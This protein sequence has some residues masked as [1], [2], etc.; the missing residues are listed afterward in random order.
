MERDVCRPTA[1]SL[2]LVPLKMTFFT[3][4]H[5]CTK[6]SGRMAEYTEKSRFGE[7]THFLTG[8][9]Q[10][11]SSACSSQWGEADRQVQTFLGGTDIEDEGR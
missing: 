10:T 8:P 1:T 11:S 9:G 4:S 5:V 6:L 7:I 3:G 2:V